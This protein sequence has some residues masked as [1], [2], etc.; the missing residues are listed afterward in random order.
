MH[1]GQ[2]GFPLTVL[3]GC[4]LAVDESA[5]AVEGLNAREAGS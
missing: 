4:H 3:P 1:Q 5:Y 2:H